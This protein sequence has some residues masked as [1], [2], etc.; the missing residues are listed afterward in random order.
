MTVTVRG[1]T[2]GIHDRDVVSP[3]LAKARLPERPGFGS[4]CRSDPAVAAIQER[5]AALVAP[6]GMIQERFVAPAAA[7][8]AIQVH[9]QQH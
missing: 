6:F 1:L 2:C 3:A 5:P 8:A 4:R 7:V 9:L